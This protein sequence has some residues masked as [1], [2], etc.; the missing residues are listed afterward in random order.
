MATVE[1]VYKRY[2]FGDYEYT[3]FSLEHKDQSVKVKIKNPRCVMIDIDD[4]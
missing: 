4:K 2:N 1:T 3:E